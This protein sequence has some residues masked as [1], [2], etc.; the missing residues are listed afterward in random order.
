M[1]QLPEVE[2]ALDIR[3][4]FIT[5]CSGPVIFTAIIRFLSL[6]LPFYSCWRSLLSLQRFWK[7]AFGG[8]YYLV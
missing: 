7:W 6:C 3:L 8:A 2:C 1:E 5:P 4:H